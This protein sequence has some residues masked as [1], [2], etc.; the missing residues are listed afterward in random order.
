MNVE[1]I[2]R[3]RPVRRHANRWRCVEIAQIIQFL[4]RD[5]CGVGDRVDPRIR[6]PGLLSTMSS[7]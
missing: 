5:F 6:R 2:A 3:R 7:T 4:R 1:L